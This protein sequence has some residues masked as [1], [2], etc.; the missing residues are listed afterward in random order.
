MD[1]DEV[2]TGKPRAIARPPV[3]GKVVKVDDAGA[4]WVAPLGS[5]PRHPVGPC[6]GSAGAAAGDVVLL[7]FTQERPWITQI[8]S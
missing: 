2:V 6:R 3:T 4:A 8:D 1:F 7:V 5:D